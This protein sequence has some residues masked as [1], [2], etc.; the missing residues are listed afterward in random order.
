MSA[1]PRQAAPGEPRLPGQV[2]QC[3]GLRQMRR[4]RMIPINLR[5][6]EKSHSVWRRYTKY[7]LARR[8]P[9]AAATERHVK[10]VLRRA[11]NSKEL[12][13]TDLGILQWVTSSVRCHACS[14]RIRLLYSSRSRV[15]AREGE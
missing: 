6:V 9:D 11:E 7:L 10:A 4:L 12:A 14:P 15:R 3:R 8:L 1:R 2:S 5:S 13:E